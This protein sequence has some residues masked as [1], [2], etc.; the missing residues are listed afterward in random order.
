VISVRI[1]GRDIYHVMR[2]P[3]VPRKGDL[4]WLESLTLG[5]VPVR[6]VVVSKVEWS[7]DQRAWATDRENEGIGVWLTVR[8]TPVSE[9]DGTPEAGE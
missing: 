5:A 7:R 6:E 3:E 2:M 1:Q 4:L 8:R 9:Y